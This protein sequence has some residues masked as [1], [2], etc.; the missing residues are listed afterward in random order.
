MQENRLSTSPAVLLNPQGNSII[1][2]VD[3]DV[4]VLIEAKPFL[5]DHVAVC[6]MGVWDK[7]GDPAGI[8]SDS[9]NKG[10]KMDEHA[11]KAKM[12]A[13]NERFDAMM[14]AVDS[15]HKRLDSMEEKAKPK[16]VV[17]DA[18]TKEEKEETKE[19]KEEIK[20]RID[21]VEARL[22]KAM[23]D[24]DFEMM[25][26][27]QAKADSVASAFGTSAPRPQLGESPLAY[28]KRAAAKFKQHSPAY[29]DVD[30]S[31]IRDDVLFNIVEKQIYADAVVTANN[32][33]V[34]N[35]GGLREIKTRSPAGHQISTF[36][37]A[38]SSWMRD[39]KA[40][41][42]KVTEIRTGAK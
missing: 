31:A 12:D 34:T 21:E 5:L 18:E 3:S 4:S 24:E 32:P 2:D 27:C 40:D 39:F 13:M 10:A 15:L 38:I 36:K 42:F 33:L 16:E 29:K 6:E 7:G 8:I 37:G 28:R 35:T 1:K 30:I 14:N 26:D 9:Y 22:P 19:E 20:K 23:S 41:A 11:E 17:A 25:A